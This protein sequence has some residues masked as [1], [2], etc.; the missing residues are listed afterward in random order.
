MLTI[1]LCPND[2]PYPMRKRATIH[3]S[4]LYSHSSCVHTILIVIYYYFL[5][6]CIVLIFSCVFSL[7][8]SSMSTSKADTKSELASAASS[9]SSSPSVGDE[10]IAAVAEVSNSLTDEEK[11]MAGGVALLA[12]VGMGI[13]HKIG[14]KAIATYV[15]SVE[16]D[17]HANPA[18]LPTGGVLQKIGGFFMRNS[19]ASPEEAALMKAHSASEA[20]AGSSSPSAASIVT[21]PPATVVSLNS[22]TTPSTTSN[23]APK[24]P[25]PDYMRFRH[26]GEAAAAAAGAAAAAS[27]SPIPGS[28]ASATATAAAG[29]V[30]TSLPSSASSTSVRANQASTTTTVSS[31]AGAIRKGKGAHPEPL[32]LGYRRAKTAFLVGTLLATLGGAAATYATARYMDVW[33]IK[34][35]AKRMKRVVPEQ[36][37]RAQPAV[38]LTQRTSSAVCN[39]T[40]CLFSLLVKSPCI[41]FYASPLC[42]L[43]SVSSC[44]VFLTFP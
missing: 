8:V 21:S 5:H 29:K 20:T 42:I 33:T 43:F 4:F 3:R 2:L 24:R 28:N 25:L 41:P 40:I 16:D 36:I 23:E 15:A 14:A 31:T 38:E 26:T 10:A 9:S 12:L 34:D 19:I 17:K 7:L 39:V 18:D 27:S 22:A 13:G 11:L 6:T 44:R 30:S 35:F 32:K 1:E 37:E